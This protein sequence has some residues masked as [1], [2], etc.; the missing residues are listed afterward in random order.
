MRNRP[1]NTNKKEVPNERNTEEIRRRPTEE[2][3][4]RST[5]EVQVV[6]KRPKDVVVISNYYFVLR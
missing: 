2:L 5:E 3:R 1:I 6:R 4:K